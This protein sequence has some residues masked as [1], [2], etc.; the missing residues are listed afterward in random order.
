MTAHGAPQIDEHGNE[1]RW[2]CP[3]SGWQSHA[4]RVPGFAILTCPDC[5]VVRIARHPTPRTTQREDQ[6]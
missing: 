2:G 1:H 5:G 3:M 6:H 4:S